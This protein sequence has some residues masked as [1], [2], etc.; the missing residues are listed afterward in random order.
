MGI[1][2]DRVLPRLLDKVM[3]RPSTHAARAKVCSGLHGDVIEIGFGTGLNIAHYPDSINK[4]KAIEPSALGF[5]IAEPRVAAS[6]VPIEF[7]GL[8]GETLE[9]E[10]EQFDTALSTW[11][12]CSIPD[13]GAALTELRRVLKPGGEF[14]FIEHGHA[15]DAKVAR[16][17]SIIEPVHKRL[18]GGCHL[19]RPIFEIITQAGFTI[20]E[21]DEYYF[22]KEPRPFGYTFT[23]RA[24]R[25]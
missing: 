23:G 8:R 21:P 25:D 4:V 6:P 19:T 18:T 17:Q 5:K 10:S 2:Q 14:H 13:V 9:L 20:I 24:R 7:A 3:G 22:P 16:W 15:P 12:L 1:Y 11:T